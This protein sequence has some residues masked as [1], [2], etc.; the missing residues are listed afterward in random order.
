[1]CGSKHT[2]K[3]ET[4]TPHNEAVLCHSRS[5]GRVGHRISAYAPSVSPRAEDEALLTVIQSLA[6][7]DA[8]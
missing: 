8:S 1:M 7:L 2:G 5:A 4:V 3:R 6:P